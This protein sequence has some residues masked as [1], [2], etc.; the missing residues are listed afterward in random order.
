MTAKLERGA[1][2][3]RAMSTPADTTIE[4]RMAALYE[5]LGIRPQTVPAPPADAPLPPRHWTDR[6]GDDEATE[7]EE[8][9]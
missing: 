2:L 6:D 7:G 4:E 9:G 3:E 1:R 8:G 5:R